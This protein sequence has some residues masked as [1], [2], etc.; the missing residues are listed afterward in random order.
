MTN[1]IIPISGLALALALAPGFMR[2]SGAVAS[3]RRT[4][5]QYQPPQEARMLGILEEGANDALVA[6]AAV[7]AGEYFQVTITTIGSGCEREGDTGVIVSE[8]SAAVMV[9]DFTKAT[10]PGVA[11][12]MILKHLR[13][14]VTLRF[15][16][17]GKAL[18]R[19]WGRRVGSDT[20]L[21]GAPT[22]LERQVTVR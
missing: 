19:V 13:H 11:C 1:K 15:T 21:A 3:Q 14:T 5:P 18:I 4:T 12:T 20:P 2:L 6:P 8:D 22:V 7:M 16:K 17:R 10:H 9:Y